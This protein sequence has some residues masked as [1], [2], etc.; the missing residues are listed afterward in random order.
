VKAS[1]TRA[2]RV[3]VVD[4]LLNTV[5]GARIWPGM[6]RARLLRLAGVR[7]SRRSG[8]VESH[9]NIRAGRRD[10]TIGPGS[11]VNSDCLFVVRAPVTI[12]SNVAL[13]NRVTLTTTTHEIGTSAKRA[14]R[15]IG[16]PIV[17]EDGCWLGTGVTVLPGVRIGRGC[18]IAAGALVTSDCAPDGLYAGVP[19]RRVRDLDD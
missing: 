9:V 3:A 6:V 13:G 19:A 2:I 14:G 7:V 18:V 11:F 8:K 5:I 10:L 12:G 15:L 4:T 17:V 1:R 16:K